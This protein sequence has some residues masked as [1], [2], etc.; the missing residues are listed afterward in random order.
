MN[1]SD[2]V[3]TLEEIKKEYGDIPVS[4]KG[5]YDW[6]DAES[7]DIAYKEKYVKIGV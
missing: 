7:I 4:V 2:L 1:I 5:D 3:K 6:E